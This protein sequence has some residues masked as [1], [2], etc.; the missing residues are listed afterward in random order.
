MST[1][2]VSAPP[3]FA[4]FVQ[5]Q[6]QVNRIPKNPLDKCTIV[7]VYPNEIVETKATIQPST[8]RI[9]AAKVDP[10]FSLL[11]VGSA[12]WLKQMDLDQPYQE[13]YVGAITVAQ[14]LITDYSNSLLGAQVGRG[15]GLFYV[16][17]EYDY[18][19]IKGYYSVDNVKGFADLLKEAK[20]MQDRWFKE[21][22][23]LADSMW[24]RSN[25][26]PLAISEDARMAAAQLGLTKAWAQDY[27]SAELTNC[28]ACGYMVNPMYPVCSNCKSVTDPVKAKEL[29]LQFV[30]VA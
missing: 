17:G 19:T 30:S 2:L 13:M 14:S 7:S 27:K 26:N 24:A 6:L 8:Y 1:S 11:V 5:P 25:G 16:P 4:A 9:P 21:L 29:G 28:K 23:R 10:G 20:S 22:I 12:S 18:K 15:P 3:G